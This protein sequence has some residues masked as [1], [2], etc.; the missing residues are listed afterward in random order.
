MLVFWHFI[1][2]FMKF[3]VISCSQIF[4]TRIQFRSILV[5]LLIQFPL[6]DLFNSRFC[7]LL[8]DNRRSCIPSHQKLSLYVFLMINTL[9]YS[10]L[11]II[12]CVKIVSR[13]K[14]I[15]VLVDLLLGFRIV[16]GLIGCCEAII[17]CVKWFKIWVFF[18]TITA[19]LILWK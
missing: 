17:W 11:N 7:F 5:C 12:F 4:I 3:L 1:V 16:V 6:L 9:S 15:F 19:F 13:L 2:D 10:S 8:L 18:R 14:L